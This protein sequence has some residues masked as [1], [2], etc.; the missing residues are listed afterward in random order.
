MRLFALPSENTFMKTKKKVLQALDRKLDRTDRPLQWILS[1]TS[2]AQ[3]LSYY[4]RVNCYGQQQ[5]S[6]LS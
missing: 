3:T 6:A 5:E 2:R 1:R 4:K